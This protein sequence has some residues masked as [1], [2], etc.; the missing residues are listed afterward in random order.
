[1]CSVAGQ[2]VGNPESG[3][4]EPVKPPDSH[5]NPAPEC[6][7]SMYLRD[8]IGCRALR[9]QLVV[10]PSLERALPLPCDSLVLHVWKHVS[11]SV[12]REGRA[13]MSEL[14]RDNFRRHS[15]CQRDCGRRVAQ[16]VEPD[17]RQTGEVEY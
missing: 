6:V 11:I 9:P 5:I 8:R 17:S 14:L 15:G 13:G 16:I 1:M 10:T 3:K 4:G 2:L 7:K 12:Q